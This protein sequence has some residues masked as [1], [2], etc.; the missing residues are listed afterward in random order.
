MK[1]NRKSR[2]KA[3]ADTMKRLQRE[4]EI[5]QGVGKLKTRVANTASDRKCPKKARR[6]AKKDLRKEMDGPDKKV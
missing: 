4:S 2:K 5:E 1:D 3:I 6:K